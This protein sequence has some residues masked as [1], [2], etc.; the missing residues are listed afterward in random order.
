M[1]KSGFSFTEIIIVIIISLFILIFGGPILGP[2]VYPSSQG[3]ASIT[4]SLMSNLKA[5]LINYNADI[6]QYPHAGK[7]KSNGANYG[8]PD[9]ANG[10]SVNACCL[11]SDTIA[12]PGWENVGLSIAIYKKR[13]N[14][15]YVNTAP[16]EFLTD[17]W[18]RGFRYGTYDKIL[19]IHS[20]GE[21]GH[22][23]DPAHILSNANYYDGKGDD[24][25]VSIARMRK[26]FG[27]TP[28]EA[29]PRGI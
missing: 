21:D 14:G 23:D 3:R 27:L 13:W 12:T 29:I 24:I 28:F 17:G 9:G 1:T 8:V 16:K 6:G 19:F 11:M 18:G 25:V 5:A 10:L 4:K 7:D 15:P 20:A 26:T 22:F 2:W